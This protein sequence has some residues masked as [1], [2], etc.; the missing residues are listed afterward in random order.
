MIKN[1]HLIIFFCFLILFTNLDAFSSICSKR[2]AS[3]LTMHF[4]EAVLGN[5]GLS[6]DALPRMRYV[7]TNRFN[8]R[9]GQD[10]KFEKRWAER[11]SR[12]ANLPGF[13]FFTLLRRVQFL[14]AD[15][16]DEGNTANYISMTVWEDK[17]AFN[18]W[19]T[20]DAFKEAHG[21]GGITDF[22]KLLTTALFILNGGPKPAF[23]DGLVPLNG[24]NIDVEAPG[25]WRNVVADG[26]TLIEPDVFV[27]MN[28]FKVVSGQEVAFENL[29]ANR[30]SELKQYAG[31]VFFTIMRRDASS[32]DDGFNYIS[33]SVWKDRQ[34]FEAWQKTQ[35]GSHGQRS[36]DTG[37][38]ASA[39]SSSNVQ[40]Q[41]AQ[42]P[43]LDMKK[44]L[45]APPK[46]A[47]YEG[48]LA[49]M[50]NAGA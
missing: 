25:G 4:E 5:T 37:S 10:A 26:K 48:K 43:K 41:T 13:R 24:A 1:N 19:R 6:S 28:R 3:R 21:G 31:F 36:R 50:S 49:L 12:I 40:T 29:W 27:A 34:S 47:F 15:Y 2:R 16:A 38:T 32:A 33:M 42:K 44:A 9:N 11:T 45:L 14:D 22:I 18:E 23:F 46:V 39:D 7:A 30:E 20:G 8:V 17:D 35:D